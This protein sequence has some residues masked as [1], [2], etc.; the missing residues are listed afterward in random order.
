MSS[1]TY[2]QSSSHLSHPSRIFVSKPRNFRDISKIS[3]SRPPCKINN[4]HVPPRGPATRS[5]RLFGEV[6]ANR[7]QELRLSGRLPIPQLIAHPY[8]SSLPFRRLASLRYDS[9]ASARVR[10]VKLSGRGGIGRRACLRCM[11]PK[12]VEVQV[13]STAPFS[14]V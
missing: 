10:R 8:T 11:D 7:T 13:L 1:I 14:L 6:H 3:G 4:I 9:K 2:T 5:G 12:G